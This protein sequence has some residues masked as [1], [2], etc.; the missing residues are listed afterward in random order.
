VDRSYWST[1]LQAGAGEAHK[2]RA[3]TAGRVRAR[4]GARVP[5]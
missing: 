2:S 4:A 1:P 3:W 5:R